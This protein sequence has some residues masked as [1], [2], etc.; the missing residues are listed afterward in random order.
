VGTARAPLGRA[1]N[2]GYYFR[3]ARYVIPSFAITAAIFWIAARLWVV[4]REALRVRWLTLAPPLAALVLIVGVYRYTLP[5]RDIPRSLDRSALETTY[6]ES[7]DDVVAL[8]AIDA[9]D[10][11]Q[12]EIARLHALFQTDR[13]VL[14]VSVEGPGLPHWSSG[15][16][17]YH[18][19]TEAPPSASCS[20]PASSRQSGLMRCT[21]TYGAV[22][23]RD[24]LRYERSFEQDKKDRRVIIELDYDEALKLVAD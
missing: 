12:A 2:L 24:V 4:R 10:Q 11:R 17:F 23:R 6:G 13:R 14:R 22:N 9:A 20:G 8:L 15:E 1:P 5:S 21:W 18:L 16:T 3:F 19:N 7:L